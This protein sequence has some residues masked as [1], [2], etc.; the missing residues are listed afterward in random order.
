LKVRG[1]K[2]VSVIGIK[3][4]QYVPNA[5]GPGRQST[6][7]MFSFGKKCRRLW[8]DYQTIAHLGL[9]TRY[10]SRISSSPWFIIVLWSTI[11]L[12]CEI[13]V[14][15]KDTAK[16]KRKMQKTCGEPTTPTAATT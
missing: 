7:S 11:S 6:C 3:T 10:A 16:K 12:I 15:N 14:P 2:G 9:S 5:L 8:F 4:L 1:H 13:I